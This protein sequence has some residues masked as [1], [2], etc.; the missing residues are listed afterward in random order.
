MCTAIEYVICDL[1][2][3]RLL[4]PLKADLAIHNLKNTNDVRYS[5]RIE[6]MIALTSNKIPM[7]IFNYRLLGYKYY[8]LTDVPS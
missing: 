4:Y 6:S 2:I 7:T 1:E 5:S 8:K 3:T